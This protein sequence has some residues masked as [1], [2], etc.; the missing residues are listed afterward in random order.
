MKQNCYFSVTNNNANIRSLPCSALTLSSK[1]PLDSVI[2]SA[3][4]IDCTSNSLAE[5]MSVSFHAS[6]FV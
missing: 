6:I 2:L 1:R 5:S 3:I 4:F